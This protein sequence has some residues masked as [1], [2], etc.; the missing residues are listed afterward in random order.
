MEEDGEE[1]EEEEDVK[2][3]RSNRKSKK[4]A[5]EKIILVR[6]IREMGIE[7]SNLNFCQ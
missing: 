3:K 7:I 4:K 5:R 1:M 2:P 6:M